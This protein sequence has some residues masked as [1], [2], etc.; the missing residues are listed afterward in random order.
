[1]HKIRFR[2]EFRPRPQRRSLQRSSRLFSCILG[3]F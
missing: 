1:M 3:V 2:P